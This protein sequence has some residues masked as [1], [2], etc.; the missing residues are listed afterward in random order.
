MRRS[1]L[2]AFKVV[3]VLFVPLALLVILESGLRL[4]GFGYNTSVF[5][6]EKGVVRNNW[7][8][9][10]SYFPWSVARPMKSLQFSA[11]KEPGSLRVFVLGGSAAHGYPAPEYGIANQIQVMLE[12]AYPDRTIEVINAAISAVNSH[13]VLPV[14]KACLKYDPDFLLVYMGNNEVVGPYGAGSLYTDYGNKLHFLRLSN[15]LKSLRLYQMLVMLAGRH[16]VASGTWKGM[17]F[18]LENAVFRDD[19]RLQT[20]YQHF[21][22]NLNDILSAATDQDCRVLLSTVAVN[23][24]D[25][26]PFISR[27][28]GHANASY[29][30]GI[31]QRGLGDVEGALAT[32]KE[33]RD[34]DGLRMRTDSQLNGIIR[35]L[36][37]EQDAHVTL[38]DSERVFEQG[39]GDGLN[40]P[41][42]ADFYDHVHLSFEGNFKVATA[43]SKALVSQLEVPASFSVSREE[44]ASEL[45]FTQWDELRISQEITEQ[46][47][48]K[49][50]YTNQWNHREKQLSRR[51][52]V[53]EM[54]VKL[55]PKAKEKSLALYET[56]LEKRPGN[57]DLKRLM[58]QFLGDGGEQG[59]AREL[60]R[61]VVKD[62][63]ENIEAQ[64]QLSLLSVLMNDIEEAEDSL[65]EILDLNPYA[66]EARNA[67]LLMLFNGKRFDEAVRYN[68]KLLEDHPGDPDFHHAYASIQEARGKA[69]EAIE[70]LK[71]ALRIDPMHEKSRI[72]MIEML[73]QK[74]QMS[75]ALRI[76]RSW[77][78]AD[79]DNPKALNQEAQLL[80]QKNEYESALE[81]YKKAMVLDPDFVVARSNFVQLLAR[82]GRFE[83]AI[84][85]LREQLAD[86]PEIQEGYSML[87]LALDVSGRRKEAL[88]AFKS[89]L[90]REPNNVKILREL[91]W[92][93]ATA[94]D[95][96]WRDGAEA[97][98]LA[99]RAVALAPDDPDFQQVLAAAYAENRRF[100]DALDTARRALQLAETNGN[101]GLSSLIR[102]CLPAYEN[103]QP[104]RAN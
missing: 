35:R 50:P 14:A 3:T 5:H 73:L 9:T 97:E 99:K 76:A 23:L 75:Q 51:R 82:Q 92:I 44:L 1:R 81:L 59:K 29:Q 87:G 55:T 19:D 38:V 72:L 79:P 18:Y 2:L 27:D 7:P 60:L 15:S 67:Y 47:L 94:K 28:D 78:L 74:R 21:E 95:G 56:A 39:E 66:I 40:I 48:S 36:A 71:A 10:F 12:Q 6:E 26:P 42:D 90:E 98:K 53:R 4:I 52:Q 68:L 30:K 22:R 32:F 20:V 13:V 88:E 61:S 100:D 58:S 57:A 101:Q 41:G 77:S 80:A 64:Y 93:K 103:K 69:M 37:A 25:C 8:F 54:E 86:D 62:F 17:D 49:V 70:Q 45:A 84:R 85:Y 31:A 104:I 102:Q 16:Q 91:A 24:L 11:K 96:Q 83:E 63:P 43:L 34:L 33:A 46:L 65:L 89:G